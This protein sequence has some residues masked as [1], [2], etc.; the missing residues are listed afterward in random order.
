MIQC[1]C[2][3]DLARIGDGWLKYAP[4]YFS[5]LVRILLAFL[6]ERLHFCGD[7]LRPSATTRGSAWSL[8]QARWTGLL[9]ECAI[10]LPKV[11]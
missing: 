8:R 9:F 6:A 7:V 5:A 3:G 1:L 11:K 4:E 2:L 10:Q